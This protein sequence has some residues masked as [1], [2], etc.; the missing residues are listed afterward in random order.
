MQR[1]PL[2]FLAGDLAR[3]EAEGLLRKRT[4]P[5]SGRPS[6]SSNDYLG[7][8]GRRVEVSS[9]AG[10]GA[11]RL[12]TGERDAHRTLERGLASWVG[13]E[14]A[15]V[16]S[17]GYATNLGV[18]SCLARPGD[19]VVSDALNHASIIDGTRLSKCRVVVTPHLDLDAIERALAE[20]KE[21][22]AFVVV[23]SYFSMDADSPDLAR[24][25]TLT[26]A[27]D[28]ALFVDEAHA[29]GVLGPDGNGLS[30][31]ANVRPDVF[32]GTLGKAIGAQGGFVAGSKELILWLWNRARSF[33][34][35]TGISP[36][37]ATLV[38]EH[39]LL[40]RQAHDAR[41][42][43]SALALR[44]RSGLAAMNIETRGEGHIVP[45]LIGEPERAVRI[46]SQLRD[47]G[48]DVRAI[49]PPTV[50]EGTS[51]IRLTVTAAHTERDIDDLLEA[52]QNVS[53]E[54]S[55]FRQP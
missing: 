11:S 1:S 35:S 8:A 24:L 13:T 38:N 19:L 2:G 37:L 31:K 46:A 7:L 55:N 28:A 48:F 16:F 9:E 17:S 47:R 50:P 32:V 43:V 18:L 53:R 4:E 27:H 14:D 42:K 26:L 21:E 36:A 22:R 29:L 12:I 3:L 52:I 30:A 6:F 15:L 20:R 54:T 25:R 34:F 39:V 5:W 51:R 45:W 10:T 41:T 40:A 33:V 44:L 49:R 23:E